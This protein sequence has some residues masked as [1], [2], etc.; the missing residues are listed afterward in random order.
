MAKKFYLISDPLYWNAV[1]V[2]KI[3]NDYMTKVLRKSE[4]YSL[5]YDLSLFIEG[6]K[7]LK[8]IIFKK[9]TSF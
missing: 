6:A 8:K 5:P 1:E 7:F 3:K 2:K 9:K 4:N